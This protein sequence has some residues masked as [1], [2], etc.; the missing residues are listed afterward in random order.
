MLLVAQRV[1][2]RTEGVNVSVYVHPANA[3]PVL[4]RDPTLAFDHQLMSNLGLA[5][6]LALSV[7]A[8]R[9]P[10]ATVLSFLDVAFPDAMPAGAVAGLIDQAFLRGPTGNHDVTWVNAGVGL[11]FRAPA[12]FDAPLELKHLKSALLPVLGGAVTRLRGEPDIAVRPPQPVS[13]YRERAPHGWRYM[14]DPID[15][16]TLTT[17]VGALPA[18]FGVADDTR[19]DFLNFAL[20][21]LEHVVV[22]ALTGV[23]VDQIAAYG[24]AV[25][26]DRVTG[27]QI[28]STT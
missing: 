4:A 23:S 2:G 25:I 11:R 19:D 20:V 26:V 9:E 3:G 28:W 16:Q 14:L 18:S 6:S 21:P 27:A 12:E 7:S 13:I 5:A 1:A 24:G 10:N 15:R 17:L 22:E 8:V